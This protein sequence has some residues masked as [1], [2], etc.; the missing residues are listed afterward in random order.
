[1]IQQGYMTV[2]ESCVRGKCKHG[3]LG[4]IPIVPGRDIPILH[5][6]WVSFGR[7]VHSFAPRLCATSRD[8]FAISS[9]CEA[10]VRYLEASQSYSASNPVYLVLVIAVEI[11]ISA[12][13]LR[14]RVIFYVSAANACLDPLDDNYQCNAGST[15]M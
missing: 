4:E 1:M 15:K 13:H 9:E 8:I 11:Q 3:L 14:H 2:V 5:D 10:L 6:A 7:P 12:R